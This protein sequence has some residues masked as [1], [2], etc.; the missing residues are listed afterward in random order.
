MY[1]YHTHIY[2][3]NTTLNVV[4]VVNPVRYILQ[5]SGRISVRVQVS[6]FIYQAEGRTLKYLKHTKK[7]PF[8][9]LNTCIIYCIH[10][11]QSH[12]TLQA[13]QKNLRKK[14]V[15]IAEYVSIAD[16]SHLIACSLCLCGLTLS[17][18]DGVKQHR[19][20]L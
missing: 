10:L 3:R 11:V 8:L 6:P 7:C 1:I 19:A 12:L 9:V 18:A 16:N 5:G 13:I 20:W 4:Y 15:K 2:V 17:Q 14:V